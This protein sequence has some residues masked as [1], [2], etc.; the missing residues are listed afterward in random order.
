M[1][2]FWTVLGNRLVA[3]QL[4]LVLCALPLTL[5][6]E[7][8]AQASG[9]PQRAPAN[10]IPNDD[11]IVVPVDAEL[12]LYEKYVLNDKRF[13]NENSN[14]QRQIRI[15]QENEI[16]AQQYGMDTQSQGS[17][18]YV[19]GSE[20][21]FRLVERSYF[22]YLRKQGE[23][24]L[25]RDGQEMLREW[26]ASDEIDSIDE[27]EAA[28]RATNRR[29]ASGKALPKNLQEQ[30]IAKSQ[31]FRFH[32]QPR[33]EQGMIILRLSGPIDARAWVGVNGRAEFN[34]QKNFEE[35]GT[36]VQTNYFVQDG[37]YLASVDQELGVPGLKLRLLNTK[38]RVNN[39]QNEQ[40]PDL[41]D[42]TRLQLIYNRSF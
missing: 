2:K 42:D 8:R 15:W 24:P 13:L 33:I 29:S 23:D 3:R 6:Q 4:A 18:Y 30:E 35:T 22:R 25:R 26:T 7:P 39:P 38:Q 37:R 40:A 31:K 1:T 20:E 9:R 12:S 14:V 17:L 10:Y 32:F 27:M 11:V 41:V 36:R 21:K 34:V 16:M 28:F 5:A 19:P